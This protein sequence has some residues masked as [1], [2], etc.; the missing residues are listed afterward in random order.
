MST[1]PAGRAGV[2]ARGTAV[3]AAALTPALPGPVLPAQAASPEPAGVTTRSTAPHRDTLAP[4]TGGTVT[5]TSARVPV[6]LEPVAGTATA[7]PHHPRT[8]AE[9]VTLRAT[10]RDDAGR[11][12][13]QTA[14]RAYALRR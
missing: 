3:L 4:V 13:R 7:V 5:D 9:H 10:A 11:R 1:G 12:T 14:V 8:G 2:A 6:A